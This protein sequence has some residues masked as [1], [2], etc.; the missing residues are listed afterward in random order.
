MKKNKLQNL[1]NKLS[2]TDEAE[3]VG[4]KAFDDAVSTLKGNLK[5][6][7]K[8]STVDEVNTTLKKFQ[9][10]IDINPLIVAFDQLKTEITEREAERENVYK[11][12]LD[13]K[14]GELSQKL[15]ENQGNNETTLTQ[16][17]EEGSSLQSQIAKIGSRKPPEIP[18]FTAP[19]KDLEKRMMAVIAQVETNIKSSDKSEELKTLI[20]GLEESLKKLRSEMATRGGGSMNRQIFVGNTNPLTRYT[21][22]NVKAG[23]NV[24]LTYANNDTT[25]KVDITVAATGGGGGTIRS[26]NSVSTNTNA[27]ATAGTDYV[28]LCTGTMTI[29]LPTAVANT[30]LYTVKNVGTGVVTVATTGGQTIDGSVS[31]SL[32]V[33]YTAVDLISDTSNWNVT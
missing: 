28:Y 18:D 3:L 2:G 7:I 30:N 8:V 11:E 12:E 25:K 4:F 32:V 27:G 20:T 16:I 26:I 14:M 29:T 1:F 21:D 15:A 23:A 5:Q 19:M 13:S 31:I 17:L 33:Q 6:S 24:T 10:R 9:Q 22:I